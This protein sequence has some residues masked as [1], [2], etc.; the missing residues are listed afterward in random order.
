MKTIDLYL[1]G[2]IT[3]YEDPQF[4][5]IGLK[6][7]VNT[8]NKY[9]D[10]EEVNVHINSP[11]GE[12]SEGFAIHDVLVNSGK[13]INTIVEG[14]CASIATVIFLAG[15]TRQITENSKFMIH[16]PWGIIEGDTDEISKY[17]EELAKVETL[18]IDFY[19]G[20]TGIDKKQLDELM[21]KETEYAAKEAVDLGFATEL[22]ST[23]KALAIFNPSKKNSKMKTKKTSLVARLSKAMK[24]L[25]G[26]E[27]TPK[28]LSLEVEGGGMI[29]IE[30][31]SDAPA[32]GDAVTVD[33][34]PAP[35]GEHVLTD[36]RKVV[37]AEGKITEIIEPEV[38]DSADDE[39]DMNAL[40][41]LIGDAVAKAIK[42]VQD[43]VKALED[44]QAENET[45]T[46]EIVNSIELIGKNL[47]SDGFSHKA[48]KKTTA[49]GKKQ[50]ASAEDAKKSALA[51]H[52]KSNGLKDAEEEE[53]NED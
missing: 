1:Y 43:S 44:K 45:A 16:N 6:H 17:A 31:E 23:V 15:S 8:L 25:S 3:S 11:G 49:K 38:E 4:G 10:A 36:G 19:N 26:E 24:A 5:Y 13:K 14:Y 46:E 52:R 51:A 42:P 18:L 53:E 21:K 22:V 27:K 37:T 9:P 50:D 2:E 35:D 34:E 30:T 39:E 40:A 33:G 20:K 32:V 7:V 48:R 12:V 41:K 29:E 47:S 28:A